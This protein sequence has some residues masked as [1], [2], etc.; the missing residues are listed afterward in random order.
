MRHVCRPIRGCPGVAQGVDG[1]RRSGDGERG[2]FG[3][4]PLQQGLDV[5]S[6]APCK[7]RVDL[8]SQPQ[9]DA[10]LVQ[11]PQEEPWADL[12]HAAHIGERPRDDVLDPGRDAANVDLVIQPDPG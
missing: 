1:P 5:T 7:S 9:V 4:R 8:E 12:E 2:K 11:E 6:N 3:H 10:S